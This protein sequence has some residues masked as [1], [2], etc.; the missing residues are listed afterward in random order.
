MQSGIPIPPGNTSKRC[1]RQYVEHVVCM[2]APLLCLWRSLVGIIMIMK[3]CGCASHRRR[4]PNDRILTMHGEVVL[5]ADNGTL[6]KWADDSW[7]T[8]IRC[9]LY[10]N[11]T[12][13]AWTRTINLRQ[14]LVI[15]AKVVGCDCLPH[16]YEVM[17]TGLLGYGWWQGPKG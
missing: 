14:P 13:A 9:E 1:P 6:T 10:R 15:A 7:K 11:D 3:A 12:N 2:L 8:P 16:V 5:V 4:H 17:T